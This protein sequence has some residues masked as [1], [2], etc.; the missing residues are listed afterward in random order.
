[1]GAAEEVRA[2]FQRMLL[3]E[4]RQPRFE[5]VSQHLCTTR[6]EQHWGIVWFKEVGGV[7]L[8]RR[9]RVSFPKGSGYSNGSAGK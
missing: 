5:K 9:G 3:R 4:R 2:F 7:R 1:M 8:R 6:N